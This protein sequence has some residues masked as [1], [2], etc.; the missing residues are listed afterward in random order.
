MPRCSPTAS[1]TAAPPARAG[2][3]PRSGERLA[4]GALQSIPA[5]A[6]RRAARPVDARPVADVHH[7]GHHVE[8]VLAIRPQSARHQSA[9]RRARQDHRLRTPAAQSDQAVRHSDQC[10]YRTRP[11][12]SQQRAHPRRAARLGV[13]SDH[14]QGGGDRRRALLG[15]RLLRQSDDDAAGPRVQRERHHPRTHQSGRAEGGAALGA[16]YP[17]PAQRGLVQCRAAQGAPHDRAAVGRSGSPAIPKGRSG[18]ACG[19]TGCRTR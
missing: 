2:R 1:P 3:S 10:E 13:P 17:R 7:H 16:R 9:E 14:V 15:R 12:V 8:T 6:A 11:G 18:R 4:G 19:F 5:R